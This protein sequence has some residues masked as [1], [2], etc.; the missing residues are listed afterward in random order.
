[1]ILTCKGRQPAANR[2]LSADPIAEQRGQMTVHD[3]DVAGED[4]EFVD[5]VVGPGQ[6]A[7]LGSTEGP[8]APTGEK[9]TWLTQ[10]RRAQWLW[11]CRRQLLSTS[12]I[13]VTA[14][15]RNRIRTTTNSPKIK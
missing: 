9:L 5:E 3:F 8:V 11:C 15:L 2:R 14:K 12:S 13:N 10:R 1:M 7:P 4:R 6:T